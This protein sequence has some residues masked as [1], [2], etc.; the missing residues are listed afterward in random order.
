MQ[1]FIMQNVDELVQ[2]LPHYAHWIMKATTT[3]K[4]LLN[5]VFGGNDEMD[6]AEIH[7]NKNIKLPKVKQY[8]K[9]LKLDGSLA[10][11]KNGYMYKSKSQF[12]KSF[13]IEHDIGK[14]IIGLLN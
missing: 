10:K 3:S 9:H 8:V 1:N 2:K 14:M 12:R 6:F 4:A 13:E 11:T 7:F 5:R